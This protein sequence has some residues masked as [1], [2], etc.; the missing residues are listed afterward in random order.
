MEWSIMYEK[1]SDIRLD[2]LDV[3]LVAVEG[4]TFNW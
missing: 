1:G 4:C 2:G 3:E